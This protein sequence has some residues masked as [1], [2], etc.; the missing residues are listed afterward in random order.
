MERVVCAILGRLFELVLNFFE[1]ISPGAP[2]LTDQ[3][4]FKG[5]VG[6]CVFRIGGSW[7]FIFELIVRA[8]LSYW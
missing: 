6:I 1:G 5:L 7:S 8:A 3:S 2:V 4:L